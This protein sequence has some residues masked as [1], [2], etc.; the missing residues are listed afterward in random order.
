MST[1]KFGAFQRHA[2]YR[3]RQAS[4]TES[5][6]DARPPPQDTVCHVCMEEVDK[7][8][9]AGNIEW[10]P[11]GHFGHKACFQRLATCPDC[12]ESLGHDALPGEGP[13]QEEDDEE[14]EQRYTMR[15]LDD[16]ERAR[17][18]VAVW[19][20]FTDVDREVCLE[21]AAYYRL[22]PL[23]YEEIEDYLWAVWNQG[24]PSLTIEDRALSV[25]DV[26]ILARRLRYDATF[27]GL[28]L[29]NNGIGPDG[30]A[31]IADALLVNKKLTTLTL[32]Q[33]DIG[34]VG[35]TC[36]ATTLFTN[37][38]LKS[39]GLHHANIGGGGAT[40][41][42]LALVKNNTIVRLTISHDTIGDDG[43]ASLA[44]TLCK[45]RRLA[46]LDVEDTGIGSVGATHIA[47]ALLVNRTLDTLYM[48]DND[49]GEV[50]TA[51]LERARTTS[52]FLNIISY[53]GISLEGQYRNWGLSPTPARFLNC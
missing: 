4:R 52:T 15:I 25:S 42:A 20:M 38:T 17:N 3:T 5:P 46:W 21:Y 7:V 26:A 23:P 43:A 29:S 39:V 51:R 37:T 35:A 50:G 53:D 47:D 36:I 31:L 40:A 9:D 45:N 22:P 44:V 6:W 8:G 18:D 28:H 27:Y 30:A 12:R 14:E 19:N 34:A 10:A 49:I 48:H 1:L 33:N 16:I 11:C 24:G 32:D 2:R 41:I 13:A